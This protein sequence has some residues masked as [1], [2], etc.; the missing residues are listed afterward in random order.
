MLARRRGLSAEHQMEVNKAV[1]NA[2]ILAASMLPTPSTPCP[3]A[4]L[5]GTTGGAAGINASTT[6]AI[7]I[8]S[9]LIAVLGH[10][11]PAQ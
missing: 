2:G 9:A 7:L 11:R 6:P 3:A 10:L 5:S 1:L 4:A 8:L